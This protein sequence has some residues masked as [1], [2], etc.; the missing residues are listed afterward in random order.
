MLNAQTGHWTGE[1]SLS[2][3]LPFHSSSPVSPTPYS[4]PGFSLSSHPSLSLT[5]TLTSDPV[6]RTKPSL[7]FLQNDI[8]QTICCVLRT[9]NPHFL[10]LPS[11]MAASLT[12]KPLSWF[13]PYENV[14]FPFAPTSNTWDAD[15]MR[16]VNSSGENCIETRSMRNQHQPSHLPFIFF[17]K[18]L[19]V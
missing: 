10:W 17:S 13:P 11:V 5:S 2:V 15:T 4:L 6:L 19:G 16:S 1:S 3:I 12:E 7:R 14:H 8:C 9:W 18:E